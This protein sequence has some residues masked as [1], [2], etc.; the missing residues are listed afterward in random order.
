MA[1]QEQ[2]EIQEQLRRKN[3]ELA[4]MYREKCKKLT[5]VTDLYNQ[6]KRRSMK[7]QFQRAASHSVSETLDSLSTPQQAG[8]YP[9]RS[10][11]LHTLR[12][13]SI[14]PSD[15]PF[16]THSNHPAGDEQPHGHHSNGNFGSGG[17]AHVVDTADIPL[18]T[19]SGKRPYTSGMHGI[20]FCRGF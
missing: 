14:H 16:C 6:L 15:R 1:A 9:R 3:Q 8:L 19:T 4:T 7:S 5:Q 13:N 10:E 12:T 18:R 11:N 20:F 2:Q 17:L